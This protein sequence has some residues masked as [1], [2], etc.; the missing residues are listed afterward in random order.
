MDLTSSPLFD[1]LRARMSWL[2]LRQGVLSQNV[3]NADTPGYV[4]TDL[5][6]LDFSK[7][8]AN[9]TS[10]FSGLATDDPRHI[11]SPSSSTVGG[12]DPTQLEADPSGQT[13][14]AEE[15]MMKVADTQ[16]KY[17]AAANLYAKAVGMMR[18]AI[19]NP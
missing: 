19:G 2:N 12:I 5:K 1:A 15:E 16:S 17:Q 14:S 10:K 7:V 9:A 13:V 6:P 8:L 3:A 18:T 4:T 11:G